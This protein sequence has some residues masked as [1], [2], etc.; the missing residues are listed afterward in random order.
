MHA[1]EK[2]EISINLLK[3][4]DEKNFNNILTLNKL[5]NIINYTRQIEEEIEDKIS[6]DEEYLNYYDMS[7]IEKDGKIINIKRSYSD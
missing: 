3:K 6:E 7:N 4:C 5:D 1:N 2:Y